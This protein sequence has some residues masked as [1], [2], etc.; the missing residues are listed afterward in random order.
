[1]SW[2]IHMI[3]R[4]WGF[5]HN[6]YSHMRDFFQNA[7]KSQGRAIDQNALHLPKPR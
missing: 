1:M 5:Q 2:I 4:S 3:A 6:V 7:F